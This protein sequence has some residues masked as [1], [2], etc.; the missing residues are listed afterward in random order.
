MQ[1]DDIIYEG[2]LTKEERVV[3]FRSKSHLIERKYSAWLKKLC[4]HTGLSLPYCCKTYYKKA[5]AIAVLFNKPVYE[6][7]LERKKPKIGYIF[8][9][10]TVMTDGKIITTNS[11]KK[12]Q[13]RY[14]E[15]LLNEEMDFLEKSAL[16]DENS[17]FAWAILISSFSNLIAARLSKSKVGIAV[18]GECFSSALT[19]GNLIGNRIYNVDSFHAIMTALA[20]TLRYEE[21]GILPVIPNVYGNKDFF[22]KNL[23]KIAIR[24][25]NCIL[26]VNDMQLTANKTIAR[27]VSI[28]D[29]LHVDNGYLN[30]ALRKVTLSFLSWLQREKPNLKGS[31]IIDK[32]VSA[33]TQWCDVN[34]I[35]TD[36]LV[37]G[38]SLI[39]H[40]LDTPDGISKINAFKKIMSR[41]M[42]FDGIVQE[43]GEEG[44]K[45]VTCKDF[46]CLCELQGI[47]ILERGQLS[48]L[49]LEHKII[50]RYVSK[51]HNLR[52]G[53]LIKDEVLDGIE[54][55][56]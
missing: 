51:N 56:S 3:K 32:A 22:N 38:L 17:A 34:E 10:L 31:N 28:N 40:D 25:R 42:H 44:V 12:M 36:G 29:H 11:T 14:G 1:G 16:G 24:E 27:W 6:E 53:W 37:K 55:E 45:W 50:E 18:S 4:I 21:K 5:L 41:L 46:Y 30:K 49:L 47:G 20:R 48:G 8:N 15:L 54:K 23:S 33:L 9:N 26:E 39:S 52:G 35:R 19:I 2:T 13:H 43:S 7:N